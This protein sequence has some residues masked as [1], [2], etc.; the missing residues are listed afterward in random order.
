MGGDGN[1]ELVRRAAEALDRGDV[2]ATL[3]DWADDAVLDWSRSHGLDARIF[4]GKDE[5]RRF[6]LRFREVFSG[7]DTELLDPI[8]VDEGV[9][10][11]ENL[12]HVRGRDGIEAQARSAWL[13]TIDEGRQ[14]SLT[15]YQTKRDALK[16]AEALGRGTH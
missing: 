14:T 7:I 2:E 6:M 15:L 12:A 11:V 1:V 10:V 9:V 13:I 4:R 16:A 5:I 8:E 3:E